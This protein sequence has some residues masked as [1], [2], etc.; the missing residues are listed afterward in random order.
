MGSTVLTA[1]TKPRLQPAERSVH[2][3]RGHGGE[4]RGR[5]EERA[6]PTGPQFSE[7][8]VAHLGRGG[9]A[10]ARQ[11]ASPQLYGL[12]TITPQAAAPPPAPPFSGD[13]CPSPAVPPL[14][15]S[16]LTAEGEQRV[17]PRKGQKPPRTCWSVWYQL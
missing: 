3:D 12:H 16:A 13:A 11:S 1:G 17:C 6:Q 14:R 8:G 9:S 4:R 5:A 10:W 15:G 7:P 2:L